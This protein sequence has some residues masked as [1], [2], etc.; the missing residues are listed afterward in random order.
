MGFNPQSPSTDFQPRQLQGLN[1][2]NY[3]NNRKI[4]KALKNNRQRALFS[5]ETETNV[6]SFFN[7]IL[8]GNGV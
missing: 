8:Y 4:K 1:P 3:L 5:E 2:P 6:G 7:C